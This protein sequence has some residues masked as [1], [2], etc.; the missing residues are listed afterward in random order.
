M[1]H[2]ITYNGLVTVE[3]PG[4]GSWTGNETRCSCGWFKRTRT[5]QDGRLMWREHALGAQ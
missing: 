5:V 4:A 1:R 2:E 3:H